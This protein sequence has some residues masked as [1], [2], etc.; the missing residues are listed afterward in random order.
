[1][2]IFL[3][4]VFCI[5]S[6]GTYRTIKERSF[7]Y[8]RWFWGFFSY[9]F[10]KADKTIS[11]ILWTTVFSSV[12]LSNILG[13]TN[14]NLYP[15]NPISHILFGFLSRELI[16]IG[17]GYYPFIEKTKSKLPKRVAKHV[18]PTTFAFALCMGN[19]IQ[20]EIQK[21]IPG[22]KALV[23]TNLPDQISDTVMDIGGITLSA[24]RVAI[25]ERLRERK[26]QEN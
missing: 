26:Q 21:L 25:V 22:L 7:S 13:P 4:F 16:E 17:N 5:L 2:L 11:A 6:Y 20:E 8:F 15:L 14:I 10:F 3:G 9:T 24:K 18:N 12:I 23:W 19:G 1:M